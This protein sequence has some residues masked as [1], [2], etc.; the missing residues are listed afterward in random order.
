MGV[1]EKLLYHVS[2]CVSCQHTN[3]AKLANYRDTSLIR[4]LPQVSAAHIENIP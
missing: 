1:G 2:L 3:Q 4:K